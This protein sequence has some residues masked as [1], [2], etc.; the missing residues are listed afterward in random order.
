MTAVDFSLQSPAM[1]HMLQGAPSCQSHPSEGPHHQPLSFLRNHPYCEAW[2]QPSLKGHSC[3][4]AGIMEQPPKGHPFKEAALLAGPQG[5]IPS[6]RPHRCMVHKRMTPHAGMT[7]LLLA[8]A[9]LH[10]LMKAPILHLRNPNPHVGGATT[11]W[12]KSDLRT[13]HLPRQTSGG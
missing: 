7:G 10:T 5:A 13:A 12:Q 9:S 11:D 6:R 2:Y 1:Q 8:T 4:G 3:K